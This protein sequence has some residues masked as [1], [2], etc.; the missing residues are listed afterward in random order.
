MNINLKSVAL[1]VFIGA[2]VTVG[3]E[4]VVWLVTR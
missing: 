3:I 2:A 1:W 4:A